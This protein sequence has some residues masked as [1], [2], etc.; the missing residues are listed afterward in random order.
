MKLIFKLAVVVTVFFLLLLTRPFRLLPPLPPAEQRGVCTA[1]HWGARDLPPHR[2]IDFSDGECL[3]CHNPH[4][5]WGRPYFPVADSC[6]VCHP[7]QRPRPGWVV[8]EPLEREQCLSCHT[9]HRLFERSTL[10]LELTRLCHTCHVDEGK[11]YTEPASHLPYAEGQCISC[12]DAHQ[13]PY[14]ALSRTPLDKLCASCHRQEAERNLPLQHLPFTRNLCL[15]CHNPHVSAHAGILHQEQR[16]LCYSCHFDRRRELRRPVQHGPYG[17]GNCT[18]CHEPHAAVGRDL[19]PH[20]ELDQFCF[21]CHEN[22]AR[23]WAGSPHFGIADEESCLSCHEHHSAFYPFLS[24]F[25]VDGRGNLCLTC[26][27]AIGRYYFQSAHAGL[28][29]GECHEIHGSRFPALLDNHELAVCARCHPGLSHRNTNHPVGGRYWDVLRRRTL[30]CSSCHNPHG[31]AYPG[32]R[33]RFGNNLCLPC[34]QEI[35]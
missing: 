30:L 5:H 23:D 25:P 14:P 32:M 24:R 33:L 31:T 9:P 16:V 11:G 34:H 15:D 17:D 21:L 7:Q 29:C 20:A 27:R 8:H 22:L 35:R 26:H 4:T 13:T 18:A 1:C 12:H 28:R 2:D 19:L 3:S 10:R 6:L